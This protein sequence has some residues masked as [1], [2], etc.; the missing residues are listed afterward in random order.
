MTEKFT[1]VK[2][3]IGLIVAFFCVGHLS[4][5]DFQE[6]KVTNGLEF[7]KA[8]GSNR[9]IAI[10]EDADIN[11]S[12]VL[13]DDE[14]LKEAGITLE[15][16]GET[17]NGE[18]EMKAAVSVFD[19]RELVLRNIHHLSIVGDGDGPSKIMTDPRY[20]NLMCFEHCSNI[21]LINLSIG[22]TETGE[23][24]GGVLHFEDC[25]DVQ[26]N[27]CDLYGCG[28]E[29]ITA[30]RTEGI[31]FR[32]SVIR[33]CSM[34]IMTLAGCLDVQFADSKFFRNRYVGIRIGYDNRNIIFDRCTIQENQG[35]LFMIDTPVVFRNCSIS[36]QERLGATR[37]ISTENCQLSDYV[38]VIWED[39]NVCT[40]DPDMMD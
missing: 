22:H 20:A 18:K 37:N 15:T 21:V 39:D 27:L 7:L 35:I 9:L 24:M 14:L 30:Y 10:T 5:S 11:I 17:V 2:A 12:D 25:K 32:S 6:I 38:K 28:V 36:H 16:E 3:V 34:S 26:M 4:A 1:T 13:N 19:G 33:D 40:E 29:G 31:R 23:C 8:L